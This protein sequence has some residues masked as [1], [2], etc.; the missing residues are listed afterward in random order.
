MHKYVFGSVPLC[1]RSRPLLFICHSYFFLFVW[2]F[3]AFFN[4]E[5]KKICYFFNKFQYQPKDCFKKIWF[6]LNQRKIILN[7]FED[8]KY[9][10]FQLISITQLSIM[11]NNRHESMSKEPIPADYDHAEFRCSFLNQICTLFKNNFYEFLD[12]QS[13]FEIIFYAQ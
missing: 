1:R 11:T 4:F 6:K 7:I 5:E 10:F 12:F 2:T 9:N 3:F 8:C 13:Q